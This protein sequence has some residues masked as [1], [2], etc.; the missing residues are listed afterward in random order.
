MSPMVLI[1]LEYLYELKRLAA[2]ARVVEEEL[3]V[4]LLR[5]S[6]RSEGQSALAV[7]SSFLAYF[8]LA[9]TSPLV[10]ADEEITKT[11]HVW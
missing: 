11:T 7:G 1:E 4:R 9:N 10:S 2:R 8:P 5:F 6:F 3:D